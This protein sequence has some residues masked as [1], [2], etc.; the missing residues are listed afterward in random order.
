MASTKAGIDPES[1]PASSSFSNS[2]SEFK[3][4]LPTHNISNSNLNYSSPIN[5]DVTFGLHWSL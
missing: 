1:C 4:K 3:N 5:P 2:N